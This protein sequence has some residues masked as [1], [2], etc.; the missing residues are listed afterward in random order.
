MM[1]RPVDII[2]CYLEENGRLPYAGNS[3]EGIIL[4]LITKQYLFKAYYV[5]DTV[6]GHK[7]IDNG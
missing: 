6:S 5:P 3:L 4:S 2:I 7:E 1:A